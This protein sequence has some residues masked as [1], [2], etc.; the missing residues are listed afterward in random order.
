MPV[1][2]RMLSL[3]VDGET[4]INQL[5]LAMAEK[6]KKNIFYFQF[7]LLIRVQLKLSERYSD[8]NKLVSSN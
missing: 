7:L 2:Y 6:M 1:M 3:K 4:C 5:N 8:T